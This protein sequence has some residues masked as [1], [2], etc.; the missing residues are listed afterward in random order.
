V[1]YLNITNISSGTKYVLEKLSELPSGLYFTSLKENESYTVVKEKFTNH[2]NFIIWHDRLGHPGSVMMQ[3]IINS[4]C[5]HKLKNEKIL[6][7]NDFPCIACSQGK[8]IVRPSQAKIGH[9]SLAFL[10]H[11]QG[12]ICGP[13]RYFMVLIGTLFVNLCLRSY[14]ARQLTDIHCLRRWSCKIIL[15]RLWV[16]FFLFYIIWT[17]EV[18]NKYYKKII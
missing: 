6:Q 13:F 5:R 7:L 9:E 8:L 1:E 2:S 11:I 18:L 14:M 4:S 17:N 15:N 10:E 3:K 12:D 16:G